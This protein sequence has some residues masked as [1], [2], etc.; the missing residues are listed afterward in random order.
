MA[1]KA[2]TGLR[3]TVAQV[4]LHDDGVQHDTG[5]T[6]GMRHGDGLLQQK[7]KGRGSVIS[8]LAADGKGKLLPRCCPRGISTM[9]YCGLSQLCN[10]ERLKTSL[11]KKVCL[12]R[13]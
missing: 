9:T 3:H 1:D 6:Y 13:K 4:C 2:G 10:T 11:K 5:E 12:L 7:L 8:L